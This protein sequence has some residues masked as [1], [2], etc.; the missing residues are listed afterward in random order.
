MFQLLDTS[1]TLPN[2]YTEREG[3]GK[4]EGEGGERERE[5]ERERARFISNIL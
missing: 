1:P 4:R 2:T 5:R 3:G